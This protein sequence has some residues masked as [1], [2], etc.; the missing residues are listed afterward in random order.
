[1]YD[2]LITSIKFFLLSGLSVGITGK[3]QECS[4]SNR[5][6]TGLGPRERLYLC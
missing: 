5:G 2:G 3:S 6:G 1:M 4:I